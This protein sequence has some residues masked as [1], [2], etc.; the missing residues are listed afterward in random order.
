MTLGATPDV[1]TGA[2]PP[3]LDLVAL[4]PLVIAPVEAR[5]PLQPGDRCLVADGESLAAG[6]SIAELLRDGHLEEIPG[7]LPDA[8]P[9]AWWSGEVPQG[10]LGLRRRTAQA[11]GELLFE[12]G[13][14]WRLATG[15]HTE[16]VETPVAGIVRS[17]RA[18][19]GVVLQVNGR[20]IPG[21]SALGVPAR[22]VLALAAGPDEEIRPGAVDV[23]S[24]GAILVVGARVDAETLTRARAMGVRGVVVGGLTGKERRDFLASEARQRAS[25]HRLPPFAVLVLDGMA[26]RAIASPVMALLEALAGREVGLLLDPPALVFDDPAIQV[27]PPAPGQ[28]RVRSGP[29]AGREGTWEGLAG[30]RRFGGGQHLEAGFVRLG[31]D[32][33]AVLPLSD[34]ERYG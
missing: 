13:D 11:D 17:A 21:V 34:L 12:S 28:V 15:Q 14:R 22:G 26:R 3:G 27:V 2:V 16:V 18:G 20:A 4:R 30:L 10:S 9:G 8:E 31:E 29:L 24:A 32:D 5:V 6:T 1:L 25:L 23:G 33:T 7:P 19:I